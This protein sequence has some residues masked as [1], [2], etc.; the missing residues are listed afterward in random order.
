MRNEKACISCSL[1]FGKQ[2][3][4]FW[5][6][7]RQPQAQSRG[8]LLTRSCPGVLIFGDREYSFTYRLAHFRLY[9]VPKCWFPPLRKGEWR[10]V[11]RASKSSK[12]A[13]T[14]GTL[15]VL[16]FFFSGRAQENRALDEHDDPYII[17]LKPGGK[18]E[19][20][21]KQRANPGKAAGMAN[22]AANLP[23][24]VGLA[25]IKLP[26]NAKVMVI[27][28]NDGESSRYGMIDPWQ[29]GFVERRLGTA[30]REQYDL[31]IL[32]I[33]TNGGMVASCEKIN[34][35]IRDSGVPTIAYITGKAFSG[36][37]LISMG[38]GAIVMAPSTQIGGAQAVGLTGNLQ[39]DQREKARALLVAMVHG[40]C[41][42][43]G[44]PKAIAR[45]MVDREVTIVETDHPT[46]RFLSSEELEDWEKNAATR[47]PVPKIVRTVK[48]AGQILSMTAGEAAGCGLASAIMP[49]RQTLLKGL[50]VNNPQ[51]YEASITNTER[52][53]RALGHP[54]WLVLL[55]I[56]ALVAL[57]WELKNPG[58]GLGYAVFGFSLG[59]MLWL[60]V[61]ADSAGTLE[62]ILFL[63][64]A[65]LLAVEFFLIPGF[66]VAGF[67]GFALVLISIVLAFIPE[68]ALQ[69]LLP[70]TGPA[71][72]FQAE[73]AYTGLLWAAL[74][75]LAVAIALVVLLVFGIKLP[76]MGRLALATEIGAL[77]SH[78]ELVPECELP[79]NA[80]ADSSSAGVEQSN[81]E[82]GALVGK[83]GV[84]ETILRPSG[85]VRM[86]GKNYDAITEGAW[87]DQGVEVKVMAEGPTALVV[88]TVRNPSQR[89]A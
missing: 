36:G 61:F 56:I 70:G 72:P 42:S 64:G 80:S 82:P 21:D 1:R 31:V 79:E 47:G 46:E 18:K 38:C 12:R 26:T 54:I 69:G 14:W 78:V 2:K 45:G 48:P 66:G 71:N 24:P 55:V 65:V 34:K 27:P 52:V 41:E 13:Y 49:D 87:I 3:G 15:L 37:A 63:L 62:L 35:A 25:R 89:M 17:D 86:E 5:D 67:T 84:T 8:R 10:S 11:M 39:D 51:V 43:N 29:V 28:V 9:S 53:S 22:G 6:A 19:D 57:V 88:R 16:A 23:T 81:L 44:Y 32:D 74:A 33:D 30:K 77:Q 7:R 60:A 58:T 20:E 83:V 85:K 68:G 73:L 75:I 40:F 50:G 76:G 59:L 4:G